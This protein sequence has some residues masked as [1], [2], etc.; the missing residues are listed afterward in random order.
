MEKIDLNTLYLLIGG[1]LGDRMANLN[2]AKELITNEIGPI[3]NQS[4][5]YETQAWGNEDQPSFLNQAIIVSSQLSPSISME[6][7]LGIEMKM[8]RQRNQKFDPRTIDIDILFFNRECIHLDHLTVPHPQI[9]NRKFVLI[10]L[11]E[12]APDY[13]H[14]V[15]NKTVSQILK[16]CTDPLEVNKFN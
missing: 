16:E 14:P 8:G 1:N 11:N 7:I 10:P 15:I 6:T 4:S 5:I 13:I 9:H 12:I 2:T 3:L